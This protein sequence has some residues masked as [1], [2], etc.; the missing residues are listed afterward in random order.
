MLYV[1]PLC[2]GDEGESVQQLEGLACHPLN[3][4]HISAK[5]CST[6]TDRMREKSKAYMLLARQPAFIDFSLM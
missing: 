3:P 6:A 1:H 2:I 5:M 4:L